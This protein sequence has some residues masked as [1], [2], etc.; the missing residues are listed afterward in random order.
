MRPLPEFLQQTSLKLILF[1]G[2]GGVGK[3]TCAAAAAL[4]L[5]R[6]FPD[7]KFLLISMD[8][9]HSLNDVFA[10]SSAPS[11]LDVEEIDARRCLA[12]FKKDN[13][14]HLAQIVRDGTFL[15]DQDTGQLMDLSMPGLD[16]IMAFNEIARMVEQSAYRCIVADTAPTGH[17]L[18]F[19]ELPRVLHDWVGVLDAMV[20]KRRYMLK[21]Y[22]GFSRKD[23]TDIF[24]EKMAAAVAVIT[25]LFADS[26]RCRF[27][28]V[29][30]PEFLI[31]Q[32]TIR[33]VDKLKA[34]RFHVADILLNRVLPETIDCPACIEERVRQDTQLIE[35]RR[36]FPDCT[37]WR[38][39]LQGA[40]VLGVD[41]L[42]SFWDDVRVDGECGI[43]PYTAT[44]MA[45]VRVE[46][47]ALLPGPDQTLILFA[48]KGGV[49]KTTLASATAIHLASRYPHKRVLLFSTD[50]AHSLSDCFGVP[51]GPQETPI[52]NGLSAIEMDAGAEYENLKTL[53]AEEV[54]TMLGSL[55]GGA[56]VDFNFD[57]EVAERLMDLSPPGLDEMMALAKLMELHAKGSYDLFVLDTAPTGHL[58]RLLEMPDVIDKWLKVFF[59]LFLKYKHVFRLPK[60]IEYMVSMSKR[61][62]LMRALLNNP[63]KAQLYAVSTPTHMAFEET[64]D[65]V[66]ACNSAGIH[67]PALLLNMLTP[68]RACPVCNAMA[69]KES[70]VRLEFAAKFPAIRQTAIYKCGEPHGIDR[71][72]DLGSAIYAG[73]RSVSADIM[74][75]GQARRPVPTLNLL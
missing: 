42:S 35:F 31:L 7:E 22:R 16:E 44:S 54:K 53:Y 9:A 11:N 33:L 47:P 48:G 12:E 61:M 28:P 20:A 13:A 40:E 68:P 1:G 63:R 26:Q 17:T 74:E 58:L 72:R 37:L 29:A 51:V 19:L 64:R 52:F 56:C 65:L 41:Q 2:K 30:V 24:I 45:P 57:R 39:P 55:A 49:G 67:L 3:T 71:L 38:I 69:Q 43:K 25:S 36:S 21:L 10:G 75:D 34:M 50:P 46:Q 73:D 15:D 18:R 59:A 32:E 23:E 62:K 4:A 8:P 14:S 6:Q 27:V 5:S 66:E 60:T 70:Q